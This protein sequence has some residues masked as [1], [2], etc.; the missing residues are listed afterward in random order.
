MQGVLL[1]LASV[2]GVLSLA[3]VVFWTAAAV[4]IVRSVLAVPTARRGLELAAK[5]GLVE[6]RVRAPSVCVVI[7]AHNEA[8][9]IGGL[10]GSLRA[11]DYP[12]LRVVLALDRCTDG[13]AGV[14]RDA[15]AG[16]SRFE[17]VEIDACP[18]DWAGKVHAVWSGVTRS[19]GAS[20]A[21]ILLFADADTMFSR[22]C[23][24]ASVALMEDR[25]LG[26][27]SLVST[28]TCT[29]WFEV[30]IQPAA[31]VELMR[32][33][34]LVKANRRERRRPFANGQF[35]MFRAA[36]YR[37]F[38]GHE[39]VKD[40]LLEDLALAR[41]AD[42]TDV[43]SGV[44]LADGV[45]TCRMY[46]DWIAF[47]RGWKRIYTEASR[48]KPSRLS[49]AAWEVLVS[50]VVL[51]LGAMALLVMSLLGVAEG[52]SWTGPAALVVSGSGVLAWFF[53]VSWMYRMSRAPWWSAPG[54]I[55]GSWAVSRILGEAA[56]EL[57]SGTPTSW[58]GR[59]YVRPVR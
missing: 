26:L 6:G 59:S 31:G 20:D 33:Y 42:W 43:A 1:I 21:E 39:V 37:A 55:A 48:R 46:P 28:L 7:P 36:P 51:P 38:G 15:I 23:V 12:N 44:F 16:D 40:E 5:T 18:S 41:Y 45:L 27:L 10:I 52:P 29:K 54:H 11:Q 2:L 50:G 49:T 30:L 19:R 58:G 3:C 34:P 25:G 47:R 56:K 8:G 14:C 17:L 22:G 24:S 9:V 4:Q 32:Q 53:V 57:R 13:T 35:M